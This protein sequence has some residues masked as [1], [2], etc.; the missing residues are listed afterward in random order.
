MTER[1]GVQLT[2]A[3]QKVAVTHEEVP[4]DD[5]TL[6]ADNPRIRFLIAQRLGTRRPSMAELM[7]LIKDQPGYDG[8]HKDI[9]KAGGLYDPIII[10]H[11]GLVIEGNSRATVYKS[12]NAGNQEDL[13][14]QTIPVVRLPKKVPQKIIEL[15]RASY[16]IAGKTVWRPFAQAE[17]IYHLANELGVSTEQIAEATRLSPRDVEHYLNAHSYLLTEVLPHAENGANEEILEKKFSHALEFVRRKDFN[18]RRDDPLVR[19][20]LAKMIANNEISGQGVR[21]FGKVLKS[22]EATITLEKN[23]FSAAKKKLRQTNPEETSNLLKQI[24]NL[25]NKLGKMGNGDIEL[26][27]TSTRAQSILVELHKKIKAAAAIA[28][29]NLDG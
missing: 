3:G 7:E 17:Q 19:E 2:I 15:L 4:I 22:P 1:M 12:L 21:D 26:L 14:W 23:G 10:R 13:R 8:V 18:E 25:S 28:K 16:H 27:Q 9:R 5:V 11:D 24:Q 20:Q 6:D 29:V